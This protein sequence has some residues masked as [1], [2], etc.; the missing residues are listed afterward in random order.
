MKGFNFLLLFLFS[1][2]S[3]SQTAYIENTFSYDSLIR[4]NY[5]TATDFNGEKD[6]LFLNI[7]KPKGDDNCLRPLVILVH[8]GSWLAGSN[9]DHNIRYM[10]RE[11]AK[12]GFVAASIT[13]RLGGHKTSNYNM[14]A[15]CNSNI[16]VPCAYL[17]DSAEF[18]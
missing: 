5:G 4:L 18:I 10:V 11:F 7:Y 16:S 13:Y 8:G 15:L 2:Y 1:H 17:A 14:Y 3:F 6:S 12:K 9:D